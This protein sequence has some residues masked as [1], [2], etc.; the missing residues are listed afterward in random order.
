MQYGASG[1]EDA[2]E[3]FANS[4]EKCALRNLNIECTQCPIRQAYL[5]NLGIY[6]TED[7]DAKRREFQNLLK[8]RREN[9]WKPALA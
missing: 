2:R 9:N 5:G 8:W 4:C 7:P 6:K 3:K 1:I